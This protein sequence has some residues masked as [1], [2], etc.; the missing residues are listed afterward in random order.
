VEAQ[1]AERAQI[2]ADVHDDS[3]QVLAAVDLRL[4]LLKRRLGERAP[5][6]EDVLG[7]LQDSVSNAIDRLR[8]LL[9]DL[10]PPDLEE[11]LTA[12]LCRAGAQIFADTPTR[13]RVVDE[14]EPDAPVATRAVAYRVA[15]EAMVNAHKHADASTVTVTVSDTDGG[16]EVS[17]SDDGA[18]FPNELQASPPGH[19]GLSSMRDRAALAG[20]RLEISPGP[21]G[22]T[23][24]RVWLP[25]SPAAT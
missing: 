19:H 25:A 21:A 9:F 15:R 5:E 23:T 16:L 10:E 14:H 3:I 1:E 2:A 4:G 12:A 24:V 11:G 7:P 22:G 8:A 6:F 18:G 17:V 20:G 13:C